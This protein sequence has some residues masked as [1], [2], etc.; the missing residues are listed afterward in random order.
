[1]FNCAMKTLGTKVVEEEPDQVFKK[2]T[3]EVKLN[4]E[5]GFIS[6]S[7]QDGKLRY[8]HAHGNNTLQDRSKFVCTRNDLTK[9]MILTT[10]QTSS[11]RVV[12]ER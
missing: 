3:C 1:M 2:L 5:F 10:K 12:E 7:I 6:K 8:F 4:R 9:L 11:I